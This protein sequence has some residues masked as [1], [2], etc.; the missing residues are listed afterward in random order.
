MLLLQ[1]NITYWLKLLKYS[2][3]MHWICLGFSSNFH[4]VEIASV[5]GNV[6]KQKVWKPKHTNF[7]GLKLLNGKSE[8][9][10][11]KTKVKENTMRFSKH[12]Q[13]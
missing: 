3:Y 9:W 5:S 13:F 2:C 7:E 12:P 11:Q 10:S 1:S 8:N 6:R 4:E